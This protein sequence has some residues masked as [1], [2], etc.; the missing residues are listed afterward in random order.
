MEMYENKA[1]MQGI[2]IRKSVTEMMGSLVLATTKKG[3]DIKESNAPCICFFQNMK[4]ELEKYEVGDFVCVEGE[5]QDYVDKNHQKRQSICAQSIHPAK[6][7]IEELYGT[8]GGNLIEKKN[9][10]RLIGT[11]SGIQDTE[12][13]WNIFLR[14]VSGGRVH[15]IAVKLYKTKHTQ[16]MGKSIQKCDSL[17]IIGSLQTKKRQTERGLLFYENVVAMEVSKLK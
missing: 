9:E 2:I 1:L 13:V 8:E 15:T 16:E 7:R 17:C 12:H 10:V 6:S 3:K 11:V 4:N 14:T 5:I